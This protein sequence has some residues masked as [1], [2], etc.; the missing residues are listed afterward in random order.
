MSNFKLKSEFK[1]S[2][3]PR[4]IRFAHHGASSGIL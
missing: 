2:G 4:K 1:P 3:D